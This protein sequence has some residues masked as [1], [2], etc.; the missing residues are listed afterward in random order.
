MREPFASGLPADVIDT[1]VTVGS[2]D[3]VHVGHRD[4]LRRL[5]ERSAASGLPSVLIT[6][7]PHPLEVVN[8][9]V[10][11][12]LLTP[13]Q[14]KLSVIADCGTD[15]VAVL[16]FTPQLARYSASMFVEDIL[17]RRFGM[18]EL[19][20]GYDHGLGR[21]REGDVE[22]LQSL[23]ARHGFPV[24][25]VEAV[26]LDDM[27]VSASAIRR[28]IEQGELDAGRRML[29]RRYDFQGRVGHGAQRGR[30]LGYPTLN[31]ELPTSRK[32]LPPPGVYAVLA[33][34][35]RGSFGGMMNLGPR[36]TFGES[37]TTLEIHLFD[38]QGDFYGLEVRVQFVARLRDTMRFSGPAELVAQLALDAEDAQ[39][40]L[41]QVEVPDTLRGSAKQPTPLP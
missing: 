5:G 18:V 17:L 2:F 26:R 3:G 31:V 29:G 12:R 6:F 30:G 15:Y 21:G 28:A 34:T 22:R 25:V 40:A 19:L 33:E 37:D 36:P 11:P 23:G 39:R 8:P 10:A 24:E 14:E 20:V 9:S 7:Q 27:P 35:P 1:V 38:A 13:G 32:L 41:T 4:L 16:P